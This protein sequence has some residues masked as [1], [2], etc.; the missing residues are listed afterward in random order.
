MNPG[1]GTT[2]TAIVEASLNEVFE[3]LVSIDQYPTWLTAIKSAKVIESDDSGRPSK[4]ELK[5]DAGMLKDRVTLDYDWSAAPEKIS[6][7]L[8]E[9]DLMT[10]MDGEYVLK[11]TGDETQVSYQLFVEVSLPVPRM[12]IA[13]GE[14]ATAKQALKELAD[15]FA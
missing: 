5:I 3:S 15:K 1:E 4:V 11:S 14:E 2:A 8:D 7:S 6:F 9:A 12:M 13:K 10:R